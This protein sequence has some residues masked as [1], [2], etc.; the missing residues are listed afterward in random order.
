MASPSIP[1]RIRQRGFRKWYERELLNGHSQL[2][3]LLLC[4]LGAMGAVEGLGN[5]REAGG[6]GRPAL[7][8]VA[9]LAAAA[10][11]GVWAMRRYL[12]HLMRAELLANQAA[13]PQCQAYARWVIEHDEAADDRA[14]AAPAPSM[15]SVCCRQCGGRW[16]I[17]W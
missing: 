4:A 2:V 17:R 16:Q 11:I 5:L 9:S 3:L 12:F 10:G 1:S 13:C 14:G 6:W 7:G 15:M 8:L